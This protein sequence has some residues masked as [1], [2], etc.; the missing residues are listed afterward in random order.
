[1]AQ[2]TDF[3]LMYFVL[4]IP[5][6]VGLAAVLTRRLVVRR[7]RQL[8]MA[9]SGL[10]AAAAPAAPDVAPAP[11]PEPPEPPGWR[12]VDAHS[13]PSDAI[14]TRELLTARARADF[15]AA[16]RHELAIAAAY[17]LFPLAVYN[18]P[19]EGPPDV[20]VLAFIVSLVAML[21]LPFLAV[22]RYAGFRSQFRAHVPG[23]AGVLR[24]FATHGLAI[25]Q[26]P[27]RAPIWGLF[28][29]LAGVLVVSALQQDSP[30]WR[31]ALGYGLAMAAHV[32][33]V[34]RLMARA[35]RTPNA[36]LLVL[37]VFGI[38]EAAL[39]TFEGLLQYWRH[40]GTFFTVVDPSFIHSQHRQGSGMFLAVI[41]SAAATLMIAAN[42]PQPALW[43]WL[44]LAAVVVAAAVHLR[45]RLQQVER[46][47]LRSPADVTARLQHLE[48]W[49]RQLD[50]SFRSLP[51][52]CHDDVWKTAVS[53]AAQV[54]S[55]VLMDLRGYSADRQGCRYEVAFLLD[56]VPLAQIVFLADPPDVERI[57]ALILE[58]WRTL[59]AASPN[60][61]AAAPPVTVYL[62]SA[63]DDRDIQGIL[64]QLLLSS[65]ENA[66]RP[67]AA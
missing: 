24:P 23:L 2:G 1:M 51:M 41:G 38:D 10:S 14:A 6:L 31:T 42:A 27:W 15:S 39:F 47:F 43:C 64:D 5:A 35:R 37:R 55:A 18:W 9:S 33:L 44:M 57:Q 12:L 48:V 28:L 63:Q 21:S 36:K 65:Q 3:S 16:F 56:T 53:Q 8:M 67:A 17:V 49:P 50:L 52:M 58:C 25:A 60:R 7:V 26:P 30:A 34:W 59:G 22:V 11:P 66:P 4:G 61:A 62:A 46:Q 40:F 54:S 29:V 13:T 32:A 19:G 45:W 20:S